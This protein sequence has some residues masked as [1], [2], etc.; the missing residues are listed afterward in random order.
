MLELTNLTITRGG[1]PVVAGV[2][3][4]LAAGETLALRGPSGCG[5]TTLLEVLAGLTAPTDG[6]CRV[7]AQR[8]GYAF[9]DDILLP[10]L[11][12][13]ENLA[14]VLAAGQRA[15]AA[16]WLERLDLKAAA[17]L[18]PAAVS[19]GMRRRA[20]LARALAVEPDLL[21]LDEPFAFQD[22]VQARRIWEAVRAE[23]AAR[24]LAVV[25]A[26]HEE[27]FPLDVTRTHHWPSGA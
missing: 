14:F 24:P 18:K 16:A 2:S 22:R 23:Q 1:R 17:D 5:K 27:P 8:L 4:K 11:T 9:Q 15:Q 7:S 21:L 19:G 20:N 3:V 12:L 25:L 13:E 26:T 6:V 10:W